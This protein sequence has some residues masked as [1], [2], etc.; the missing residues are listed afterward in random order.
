[1]RFFVEVVLYAHFGNQIDFPTQ[2][3]H[4][5]NG[6]VLFPRTKTSGNVPGKEKVT[7]TL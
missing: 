2:C 3:R 5:G 7:G 1:M 6:V 4:V